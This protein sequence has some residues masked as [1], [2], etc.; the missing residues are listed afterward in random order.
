MQVRRNGQRAHL[1]SAHRSRPH[2]CARNSAS[3][4]RGLVRVPRLDQSDTIF[5]S[6]FSHVTGP[7]TRKTPSRP[8][9]PRSGARGAPAPPPFTWGGGRY[10]HPSRRE[11][12][13]EARLPGG[14]L[15]SG[16]PVAA[17]RRMGRC[18]SLQK[19][20]NRGTEGDG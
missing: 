2:S 5:F 13:A 8:P 19:K 11:T 10:Q 17:V 4:A 7:T 14:Q 6:S 1:G 12:K 9:Q 15:P 3:L 20:G 16:R 18:I